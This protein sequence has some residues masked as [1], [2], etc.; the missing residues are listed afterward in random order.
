VSEQKKRKRIN[1]F[2]WSW[3][4]F[5]AAAPWGFIL[6]SQLQIDIWLSFSAI[7]MT[8]G[9]K[10]LTRQGW[11]VGVFFFFLLEYSAESLQWWWFAGSWD[12]NTIDST[13]ALRNEQWRAES[14]AAERKERKERKKEE[15]KKIVF[16]LSFISFFPFFL[17]FLSKMKSGRIVLIN[18]Q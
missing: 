2:Y 18:P 9:K 16:F 17:S 13:N 12:F 3:Y 6:H 7:G 10:I 15:N 1:H 5:G 14:S 8:A 4:P 11:R